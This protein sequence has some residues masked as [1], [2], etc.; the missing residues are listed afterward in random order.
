MVQLSDQWGDK[1]K[2][3]EAL[4]DKEKE[5]YAELEPKIRA[6]LQELN[7]NGVIETVLVKQDIARLG[8]V[9]GKLDEFSELH[10]TMNHILVEDVFPRFMEANK[11]FGITESIAIR[12]WEASNLLTSL[13]STELFKLLVLFHLKRGLGQD[14]YKISKFT[15]TMGE[16]AP[17]AWPQLQDS[18]DNAFRNSIA[19]GTYAF[20][21]KDNQATVETYK[22]ATLELPDSMELHEFMIRTKEQNVLYMCGFNVLL[23]LKKKGW[24][25]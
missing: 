15:N 24:F 13:L 2:N 3:P 9:L 10:N 12:I 11:Q 4:G 18:V 22:D 21:R 16:L 14:A 25:T 17:N 1:V 6:L 19:H 23:D 8:A 5:L 7:Q 20:L